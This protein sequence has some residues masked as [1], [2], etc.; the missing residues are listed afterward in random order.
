M[1]AAFFD[2]DGT[3]FTGH[4]WQGLSQ[5]G[6]DEVY[7]K[8]WKLVKEMAE[9]RLFDIAAHLDL[10]KKFGY[11][12]ASDMRHLIRDA[13]VSISKNDLVVEYNTAGFGKPCADG[14]PS[15]A[16]LK[17][18]KDLDIRVALSS[19]AHHPAQLLFEFDRGVRLLKDIGYTE[20]ARFENRRVFMESF[21]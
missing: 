2:L 6:R 8:Y 18:C 11:Y 10:P 3:L 4:I 12:P 7:R 15:L 14:Y 21:S 1:I 19:D 5:H 16:I 13:L 9:S 20:I 17:M